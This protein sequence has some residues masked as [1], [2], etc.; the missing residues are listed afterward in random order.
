MLEALG[1][2]DA[3]RLVCCRPPSPRGIDPA[4]VAEAAR[5]LG[6]DSDR[7]DVVD[8]VEEAVVRALA[9][10]APDEQVIVTGSLYVVGAARHA[11]IR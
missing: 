5:D 2:T 1:A 6:V 3:A 7:I 11:L 9:V 8:L 4:I 10:T